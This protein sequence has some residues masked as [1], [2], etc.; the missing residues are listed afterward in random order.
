[1]FHFRGR[2]Q[3]TPAGEEEDRKHRGSKSATV[4]EGDDGRH[5]QGP[6]SSPSCGETN[7][8]RMTVKTR[9]IAGDQEFFR[10]MYMTTLPVSWQ[11]LMT[12]SISS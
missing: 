5:L 12:F 6:I 10:T 2:G 11:W 3:P 7:A 8:S 4:C 1:M 9:S